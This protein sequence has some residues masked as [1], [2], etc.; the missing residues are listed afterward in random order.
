MYFTEVLKSFLSEKRLNHKSDKLRKLQIKLL[1]IS[2]YASFL[3]FLFYF[4]TTEK[5]GLYISQNF[6]ISRKI[7][8]FFFKTDGNFTPTNIIGLNI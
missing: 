4:L 2:P 1:A 5:V 6:T 8:F 7:F 3:S